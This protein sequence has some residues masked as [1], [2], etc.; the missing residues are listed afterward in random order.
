MFK[1]SDEVIS[2]FREKWT[3]TTEELAEAFEAFYLDLATSFD[4][5]MYR[6]NVGPDAL[7]DIKDTV[8]D[9]FVN[10]YGEDS[11]TT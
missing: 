8:E 4:T 7:Q 10:Q 6:E 5:A 11:I 3:G 1:T 9:Y 2:L